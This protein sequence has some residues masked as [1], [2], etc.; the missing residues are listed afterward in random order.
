MAMLNILNVDNKN[1]RAA[2]YVFNTF[3][4]AALLTHDVN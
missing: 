4:D 2:F 1:S 3:I